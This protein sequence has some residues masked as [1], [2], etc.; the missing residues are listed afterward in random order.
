MGMNDEVELDRP[1]AFTYG[2]TVVSRKHIRN[3][4]T[5]PGKEIG[6][7]LIKKGEKG[8]VTSIGTFLQRFY[9]YGVDF[10][11]RGCVVGMKEK[12]LELAPEGEEQRL[13]R[14]ESEASHG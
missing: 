3:D 9:I 1:P 8:V 5:F 12:E 14:P 6:E 2:Q 13:E 4:G 10:Y 7:I 11:E